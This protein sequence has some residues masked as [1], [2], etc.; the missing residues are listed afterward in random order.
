MTCLKNIKSIKARHTLFK[1]AT[2]ATTNNKIPDLPLSTLGV[3][4]LL[5]L[6]P[7]H[8]NA[9]VWSGANSPDFLSA[10]NWETQSVPTVD[11]DIYIG[12]YLGQGSYY[13][14]EISSGQNFLH[15][16]ELRIGLDD[17]S[18]GA[19]L[20]IN[21]GTLSSQNSAYLGYASGSMANL[22]VSGTD[23]NW[24][25]NNSL[26]IGY[27]GQGDLTIAQGGSLNS[28]GN[29]FLGDAARS[30]ANVSLMDP[31]S[32]WNNSG[33]LYVG[34]QGS[35]YMVISNGA[36]YISHFL[37]VIGHG[38]S[39]SGQVS[40]RGHGSSW[41]GDNALM[42][43]RF[44]KGTLLI[45]EGGQ[46]SSGVAGQ[47]ATELGSSGKVTV[48]GAGSLWSTNDLDIGLKGDGTLI[49]NEQGQVS[50]TG[51][52]IIA[53][54][55]SSVGTLII[56]NG[57]APGQLLTKRVQ[58]GLGDGKI[59]FNHHATDYIFDATINDGMDNAV[60]SY[61]GLIGDGLIEA[62]SGRTVLNNA[63]GNFTGTLQAA[64][65]GILQVNG[66]I[67]SATASILA[68]GTLEGV[69]VV[70]NTTNAG[71]LSPGKSIGTF[72]INGNYHGDDGELH[73]ETVLGDDSSATDR[74][75]IGGDATGTTLVRVSNL[76]GLGAQTGNG[77]NLIQVTGL[78][79]DNAFLLAGDYIT[80]DGQQA[81]VAGAYAYTL[82]ASG[83]AAVPGHE[84]Y[85]S[86]ALIPINRA[87]GGSV[88]GSP[89][90]YQAGV[91]LYEQYPQVLA[92]LNTLPTLQQRVGNYSWAASP[93]SQ[94]RAWG[95][96][97]GGYQTADP[98]RSTSDSQRDIDVWKLQTGIDTPLNQTADG[99]L[100]VGGVNF[101]YGKASAD[102]SSYFGNGKIDASGYGLGSNLTWYGN[103]GIY[104]DGQLQ[105]I[106]FDSSLSTRTGGRTLAS[107]NNGQGY[108]SSVE[109]GKRYPLSHGLSLTP[110]IQVNYSRVDFDT[111][112]DAFGSEVSLKDADSLQARV[113]VSLDSETIWMTKEGTANRRYIY[114][115][116]NL[117]NELLNGSNVEV[118]NSRFSSRDERQWVSVGA[119]GTYEWKNGRYGLYSNVNLKNATHNLSDNYALGGTL[120]IRVNW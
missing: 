61:T 23:S 38:E 41:I 81:V 12:A 16:G 72:T 1:Y 59:I 49:L 8:V 88:V 112:H 77:I 11:D 84:W 26:Y 10:N 97:E 120:G 96:I 46:V 71:I 99:S 2:E 105:M 119:G 30:R 9:I 17:R 70:G 34:R 94:S 92:A 103:S 110:Q 60:G 98:T 44:G 62:Y 54:D 13:T 57:Y 107:G 43:G 102:I 35:A 87:G 111:F 53:S 19:S 79:E 95:R 63:H 39:S 78:A 83:S 75:L 100:L 109:V 68:G 42:V 113:G 115:N 80:D 64:N 27:G 21:G 14:P 108:A 51:R 56:G 66:D 86:S 47:I 37:D 104:I 25:V 117:H 76:G 24:T 106:W 91:P 85:L 116:L 32:V 90:R 31:G 82:Q 67:S 5:N 40:V 118:S 73:I 45:T 28:L 114:A 6:I 29:T 74:L 93:D 7:L 33:N 48:R 18:T 101:S 36:S 52:V 20:S 58:F 89:L 50:A 3:A 4:I 55:P 15:N 65:Q 22:R 69:G